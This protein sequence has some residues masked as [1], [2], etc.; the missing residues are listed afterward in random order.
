[1]SPQPLAPESDQ[2]L[3]RYH[4][5]RE[6]LSAE[7]AARRWKPEETIPSEAEIAE[8]HQVSI[9]TVR[10][11]ID[12]LVAAY[13]SVFKAKARLCVGR[14]F[15]RRSFAFFDLRVRAEQRVCR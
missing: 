11:A 9:G 14:I 3:P 8:T 10:K 13:W 6:A 5:V 2:R 4:R 15:S 7:I 1:M 12:S